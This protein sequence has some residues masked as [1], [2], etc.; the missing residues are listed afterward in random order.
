VLITT[1]KPNHS[2]PNFAVPVKIRQ[3]TP[4]S[5]ANLSTPE[6]EVK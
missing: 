1:K 5:P 6:Y 2:L 3:V 4:P